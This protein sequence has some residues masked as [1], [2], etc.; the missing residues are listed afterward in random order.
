MDNC[1]SRHVLD[2]GWS[3][4][5]CTAEQCRGNLA[6]SW[7]TFKPD[8][9]RQDNLLMITDSHSISTKWLWEQL[10]QLSYVTNQ[11]LCMP[12]CTEMQLRCTSNKVMK[13]SGMYVN[14]D[15]VLWGQCKAC[16]TSSRSK[17]R[18]SFTAAPC[19]SSKPT[20][21][22]LPAT[23]AVD[24]TVKPCTHMHRAFLQRERT[25]CKAGFKTGSVCSRSKPKKAKP[26]HQWEN[27]AHTRHC[28]FAWLQL[29]YWCMP[30]STVARLSQLN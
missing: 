2:T 5:T 30:Y 24:N 4:P 7:V 10:Q 17:P 14:C 8:F 6:T 26:M 3:S 20:T 1:I 23:A 11:I 28:T 16:V 29:P 21:S 25:A 13:L 9:E 15:S 22:T 18:P 12:S 27:L 19:D